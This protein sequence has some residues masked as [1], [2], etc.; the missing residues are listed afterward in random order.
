MH[1]ESWPLGHAKLD[2]TAFYTQVATKTVR[3]VTSPLDKLALFSAEG[4]PP[5][6]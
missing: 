1:Y 6:G 2:T 5:G 3:A 4:V